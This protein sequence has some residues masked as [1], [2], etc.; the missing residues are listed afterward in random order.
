MER[1]RSNVLIFDFIFK[2]KYMDSR[3]EER[4]TKTTHESKRR[5]DKASA[6]TGVVTPIKIRPGAE[7]KSEN[8]PL[9]LRKIV[10][11]SALSGNNADYSSTASLQPMSKETTVVTNES[12]DETP[13]TVEKRAAPKGSE[14]DIDTSSALDQSAPT[15]APLDQR[16][17]HASN[18]KLLLALNSLVTQP[19]VTAT[20]GTDGN[21]NLQAR[22][23]RSVTFDV[24]QLRDFLHE[25]L[26]SRDEL[27]KAREQAESA[28]RKVKLLR[29]ELGQ[30][31]ELVREDKLTGALNRRGLD[32]AFAREVARSERRLSPLCVALL[33]LDDFK[34]INDTYGHQTGDNALVH[35]TRVIKETLRPN[36][37]FSRY[38]GEEFLILL[39]DSGMIEAVAAISR[40]QRELARRPFI[41]GENSIAITF[42]AGVALRKTGET[43]ESVIARADNAQYQAKQAGKNR[44]ISAG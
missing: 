20:V 3:I 5:T 24:T 31:S 23:G 18:E 21:I 10:G 38:G 33:D 9:S 28:E 29:T 40:L 22:D 8:I 4:R 14:S 27:L 34:K 7:S 19:Q 25:V 36:D 35:L 39:P 17:S 43:G 30:I 26:H 41:H 44:V 37:I 2:E 6:K 11:N 42:S 1:I 12:R 32:E 13:S 16:S 15:L